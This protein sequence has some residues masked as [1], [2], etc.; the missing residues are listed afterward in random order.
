MRLDLFERGRLAVTSRSLQQYQSRCFHR[1]DS[2]HEPEAGNRASVGGRRKE[3]VQIEADVHRRGFSCDV[4]AGWRQ[5]GGERMLFFEIA[6]STLQ[7][8]FHDQT[9]ACQRQ[10]GRVCSA[11]R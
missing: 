4:C 2:L 6:G 3:L 9:I 7:G 5:R 1:G 8:L 10:T 11:R